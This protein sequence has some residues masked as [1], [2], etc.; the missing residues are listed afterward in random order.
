MAR[1]RILIVTAIITIGV[2]VTGL[3]L[4][5]ESALNSTTLIAGTNKRLDVFPAGNSSA[6]SLIPKTQGDEPYVAVSYEGTIYV[7]WIG[8]SYLYNTS[9]I[10][11]SEIYFAESTD[12]GTTFSTP[13]E[14]S[15]TADTQAY[16]AFDPSIA[17]SEN[18]TVFISYLSEP[19][20]GSHLHSVIVAEAHN[21][22]SSNQPVYFTWTIIA[23][24]YYLDRPWLTISHQGMIYVEWDN[25]SE[26]FLSSSS[27][28]NL[29]FSAAKALPI[30]M[31]GFGSD[32]DLI[33]GGISSDNSGNVYFPL[34][35]QNKS[36]A[37]NS[38]SRIVTLI[39]AKVSIPSY[40]IHLYDMASVFSPYPQSHIY[41]KTL[42]VIP[43]VSVSSSG[44][45]YFAYVSGN[46]TSIS[47]VELHAGGQ[48]ISEPIILTH[49]DSS[50]VQMPCI[51]LSSNGN[52]LA[53]GWMGNLTGYWNAY[54]TVFNT[55]N[56]TFLKPVQVS[57][58]NGYASSVLNWHGD[59]LGV[60]FASSN[61][62]IMT[63]G[64]GRGLPNTY[65]DGHI[66]SAVV[67]IG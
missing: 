13:L 67:T 33:S 11:R 25:I 65:G 45:V 39:L 17:L 8:V 1:L 16:D 57:N 29:N 59:F 47:L 55:S 40:Q 56:S 52:E 23:R 14:V 53:V 4:Y 21:L 44:T 38:T 31:I 42:K 26:V 30:Q 51:L 62:F 63:W 3:F 60:A 18:G 37:S 43:S 48:N 34:L 64:D 20:C 22:H 27:V 32:V 10:F 7:V 5:Q 41:Q 66:Y 58:A 35:A 46:G 54:A 2:L 61:K 6:S 12:G 19:C 9:T 50:L 15:N 28:S 24:D 49:S 36:E